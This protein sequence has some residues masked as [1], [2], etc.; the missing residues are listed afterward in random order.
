MIT[1]PMLAGTVEDVSALKF[2][3]LC[4]PKLDGIRCLIVNG[5]AVSRNFKPIQNTHIRT[6]LAGLP[7]GLDGELIV[8]GKPFNEISGDVMRED[9]T[10]NFT[11][12]VFDLHSQLGYDQ[13]MVQLGALQLP[14]FVDKV[15]PVQVNDVR[16]LLDLEQ[17]WLDQG[18]EGVMLRLPDSPYKFGRSTVREQWLLKLK[19]FMDSEAE[20]LECVE[21]T[22]NQNLQ[23]RDAFGRSKRSTAMAGLV[24]K[25]TLGAFRV[26][27]VKTGIEFS[28]GSGM[29]DALRAAV[30][31]QRSETVGRIIKYK[32]QEVGSVV[33]P[34]FPVFLG[35]RDQSDMS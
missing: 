35:F 27:D 26:R 7:E 19:R 30:W 15:L 4:T 6:S 17:Q 33:A 14:G 13:R 8:K 12:M 21:Q 2:P 24:P 34:R 25:G 10:P 22:E 31:S 5:Q 32:S 20:V 29:D 3:V 11:F 23:E 28:I 18:Y 1:K 9:G 16:G